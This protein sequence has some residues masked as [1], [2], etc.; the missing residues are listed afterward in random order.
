MAVVV[1]HAAEPL[2]LYVV[3][4]LDI[5]LCVE[6]V[7][8]VATLTLEQNESCSEDEFR[9]YLNSTGCAFRAALVSQN[10]ALVMYDPRSF[11]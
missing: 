2:S 5:G 10:G 1:N 8:I 3:H 4:S 11:Q 6:T 7:R 9:S